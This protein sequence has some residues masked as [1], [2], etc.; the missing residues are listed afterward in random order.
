MEAESIDTYQQKSKQIIRAAAYLQG[1]AIVIA[2]SILHFKPSGYREMGQCFS[3][4]ALFASFAVARW[5]IYNGKKLE[6]M[7]TFSSEEGNAIKN[8]YF[9]RFFAPYIFWVACMWVFS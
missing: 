6:A 9:F 3:I 7:K 2:G 1:I 4:L 8:E 5:Y